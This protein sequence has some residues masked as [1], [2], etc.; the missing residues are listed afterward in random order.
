MS[1]RATY[2]FEGAEYHPTVAFYI[3]YD[4]YHEGAAGYLYAMLCNTDERGG[5]AER[6]IRSNR[7]AEFTK[8][9][10]AHGDTEHRYTIKPGQGAGA[11]LMV[12]DRTGWNTPGVAEWSI[13]YVGTLAGFVDRE[14]A[15]GDTYRPFKLVKLGYR[16]TWLNET[17][18]A[19]KLAEDLRTLVAWDKNGVCKP[20]SAN[21]DSV[22]VRIKALETAFPAL[23][24]TA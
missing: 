22:E 19:P 11:T 15:G 2:V 21:R 24:Q 23:A 7:L 14:F 20:G 6:F 4:G 16:E 1:T 10:E 18:A 9:H 12:H 5:L 8:S 3:H 13:A 17:T